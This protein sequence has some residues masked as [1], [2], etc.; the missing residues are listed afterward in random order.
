MRLTRIAIIL[1]VAAVFGA[2]AARADHTIGWSSTYGSAATSSAAGYKLRAT[3]GQ[4]AAGVLS[5]PSYSLVAG[6]WAALAGPYLVAVGDGPA[7]TD[8]P[9]TLQLHA[10]TP[11]PLVNHALVQFDL[12]REGAV[13]LRIY[14]TAGRLRASIVNET[15]PAGRY[16]RFWNA[17][18]DDGRSLSSGVYFMQLDAQSARSRQRLVVVR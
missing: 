7:T 2:P 9:V 8:L 5:G 16:Q 12:P 10:V 6:F 17:R 14:D 4:P 18:G 1:G 3:A 15:L 13:H 11:N